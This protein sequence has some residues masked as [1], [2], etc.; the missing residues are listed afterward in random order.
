MKIGKLLEVKQ[1]HEI[2]LDESLDLMLCFFREHLWDGYS[3]ET[4]PKFITPNDYE[5]IVSLTGKIKHMTLH[6]GCP[7]SV[8]PMLQSIT[9]RK[10]KHWQGGHGLETDDRKEYRYN[11][12]TKIGKEI[13]L[14][15]GFKK[16]KQLKSTDEIARVKKSTDHFNRP[17]TV[18]KGHFRWDQKGHILSRR[19][20]DLLITYILHE[21]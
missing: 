5:S 17:C 6:I 21:F 8:L 20:T 18:I 13:I 1:N 11:K 12:E 3:D 14:S 19:A 4:D 15:H 10:I 9:T 16:G 2:M 7:I